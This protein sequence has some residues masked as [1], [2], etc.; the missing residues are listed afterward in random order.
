MSQTELPQFPG[1]SWDV[2][3]TNTEST[4][5]KKTPVRTILRF[6]ID[7]D[8]TITRAPKHFKRLIDALLA[9][10]N[11]VHIVTGRD[12]GRLGETDDLLRS[13]GIHY[14]SL[15]MKPVEW[16]ETIP[17]YK[18]K[19]VKDLNLHLLIDDEEP[20]CWAVEFRT[21]ALAAHMLP[22]PD[23]LAEFAEPHEFVEP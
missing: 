8:G 15:V 23:S 9:S 2:R 3:S 16:P 21:G 13:M 4:E 14:T 19:A 5:E 17:D 18:V 20:N 10:G 1:D 22:F 11:D 12:V 7:I 6:G